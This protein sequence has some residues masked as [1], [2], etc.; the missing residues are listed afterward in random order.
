MFQSPSY[1]GGS[2]PV[3]TKK[4]SRCGKKFQSPSYRGGSAPSASTPAAPSL[5]VRFN[6]LL[7]GAGALPSALT[8]MSGYSP[9]TSFNPLLIGAGALPGYLSLVLTLAGMFQSPSY[10]GGSAPLAMS[11][12]M[13]PRVW[14]FQSPSYRGGSA[15]YGKS[16]GAQQC[17]TVSIPFLSGR[18]RSH[19]ERAHIVRRL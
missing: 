12:L 19:E 4:H 18:E 2:P 9:P 10:R 14:V 17:C 7:I 6:P 1:R 16:Q 3:V 8:E 5:G 13:R 11:S 15:P